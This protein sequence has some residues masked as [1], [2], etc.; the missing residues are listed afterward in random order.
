MTSPPTSP[1]AGVAPAH[2][3]SEQQRVVVGTTIGTAIEWYD[4]FLYAQV[5]GIVFNTI[6]FSD[7]MDSGVRTLISFLTVGISFLFRPL[8]AFL[9]GHFSDRF[10][11]R[12]VLMVTLI[13]MGCA[14]ALIGLL[15]TYAHIGIWAPIL[16]MALRIIQGV[17]AGG[18]WGSAVLLAVEH[19]PR[20]KRGLFG[21]GPQIGVPV[22][23]LMA[24][25]V[26][27]IMDV[28]APGE[29]F[30]EWGWRIPFL[31]SVLLV[32]VGI[33]IR[34]GV[35]ES[36]VYAE[37]TE[38]PDIHKAAN[39]IGA[40]FGKFWLVLLLASLVLAGNGAVGYMTTGGF[41]Q[42]YA[43]RPEGLAM[44]RGP[45][46]MAVTLSGFTWMLTTLFAGWVSDKIGR[47]TTSIVGFIIQG[48]GVIALFPLVETGSI[49][50]LTFGLLFLTVGLGLTYGQIS[51]KFAELYP[52]AIRGSGTSITYAIASILGGAFAPMIATALVN[53]TGGTGAVTAYL[54]VMT[55]LGLVC[56]LL[57]RDRTRIPLSSDFEDIQATSHFFWQPDWHPA[58]QRREQQVARRQ[59]GAMQSK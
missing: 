11:R 59:A 6:M 58:A 57:L 46:L 27:V 10:G 19:A 17:S 29:A 18:E 28:I 32:I 40:L 44:E 39:P 49:G 15:P 5:A 38:R 41:I 34:H 9:A 30:M 33:F 14:T 3:R 12:V 26:L 25:G 2:S 56:A 47:R 22:G 1:A 52:A 54:M 43:L 4:Y 23:L 36:P 55:L 50:K 7:E 45:V 13:A 37:M 24:S 8:G 42:S 48:L 31:L 20:D 53:R 35:E 51:S 16:L 21:A